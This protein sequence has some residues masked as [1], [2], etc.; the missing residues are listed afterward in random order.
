MAESLFIFVTCQVGAER[1][2]KAEVARHHPTLRFAFS[3][4]GFLTFRLPEGVLPADAAA[5]EMVFA[6]AQGLSLGKAQG[7]TVSDRVAATLAVAAEQSF[8]VVHLWQRDLAAPGHRS[9]Q[10]GLTRFAQEAASAV[11]AALPQASPEDTQAPLRASVNATAQPG[12]T[13][14]DVVIV[15]PTEW[16][17][18]THRAGDV[19][20]CWPGGLCPLELPSDAVSRAWLK[21]E[22]ALL[23]SGLPLKA[24]QVAAEIGCA[25][26]GSCQA[27]LA[28]GLQVI[29]IDPAEVDPVVEAHPNFTHIRRRGHEVRRRDFRKVRWLTADMNVAPDY[30]LDTVEAI[31]SHA[32]VDIRGMLLTLKL[33]EWK[34]AEQIPGYLQRI[35]SWGFPRVEARQLQHNRQEI[36]VAATRRAR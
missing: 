29:G 2:L 22:E 14:L 36:C 19:P 21:L 7:E 18:G 13:V 6:R 32:E 31:V 10:P 12:Q 34:L 16:W 11:D 8:D 17:I 20:S 4:P 33:L 26:G 25:P 1:A 35:R 5:L 30:T 28:R 15:D 3:R 24:G 23:W 9:F 27:L